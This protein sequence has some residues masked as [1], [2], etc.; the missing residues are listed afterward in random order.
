MMP[1]IPQ[2]LIVL[3]IIVMVFGYGRIKSLGK[4]AGD[5]VKNYKKAV[6]DD[7]ELSEHADSMFAAGRLRAKELL[8][9]AGKDIVK[10]V[11]KG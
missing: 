1:S 11:K 10:E 4:A 9:K 3:L 8:G 2:A 6:A 5:G 7:P